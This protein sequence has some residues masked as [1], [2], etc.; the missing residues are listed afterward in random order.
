M[1]ALGGFR[2]LGERLPRATASTRRGW[3]TVVILAI[4]LAAA[5]CGSAATDGEG[6]P[7]TVTGAVVRVEARSLTELEFLD[8]RDGTGFVWRFRPG[9]S[10]RGFT[11]SHLREHMVQG[12]PV[13]VVYRWKGD[14]P[15]ME[16][17][18]D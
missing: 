2:K 3:P 12:L 11:P 16:D 17:V 14:T 5:G 8:V 9:F 4:W 15:L 18:T 6:P 7:E 10:Y 1:S 13:T